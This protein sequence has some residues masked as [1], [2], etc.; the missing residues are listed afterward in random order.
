[1]NQRQLTLVAALVW[2]SLDQRITIATMLG[3]GSNCSIADV[4]A[5]LARLG[6]L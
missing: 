6:A 4:A 2:S 1:M 5:E 3:M